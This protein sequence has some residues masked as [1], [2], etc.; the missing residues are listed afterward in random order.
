MRNI[1]IVVFGLLIILSVALWVSGLIGFGVATWF[2]SDKAELTGLLLF[3]VA[4]LG[5]LGVYLFGWARHR[6][7]RA[8]AHVIQKYGLK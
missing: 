8:N 1:L 2:S 6:T 4:C 7:S 3:L 5:E